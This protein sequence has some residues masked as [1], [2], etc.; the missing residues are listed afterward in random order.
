MNYLHLVVL[1]GS[2]VFLN[3]CETMFRLAKP[4]YNL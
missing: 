1:F 2:M 4:Y 3:S